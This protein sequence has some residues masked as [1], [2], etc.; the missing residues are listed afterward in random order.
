MY[1]PHRYRAATVRITVLIP[2]P[3]GAA[4]IYEGESAN[5]SK[6]QTKQ[7]CRSGA[8]NKT[9]SKFGET[10]TASHFTSLPIKSSVKSQ[11]GQRRRQT[12]NVGKAFLPLDIYHFGLG[13]CGKVV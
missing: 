6:K 3:C 5:E 2:A 12:T 7:G 10:A 9:P 11:T 4:L 8:R 1:G 13:S